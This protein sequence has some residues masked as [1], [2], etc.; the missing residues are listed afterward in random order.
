MKT[1]A[2]K[3]LLPNTATPVLPWLMKR[4]MRGTRTFSMTSRCLMLLQPL[5]L[6]LFSSLHPDAHPAVLVPDAP[7]RK[8]LHPSELPLLSC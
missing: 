2:I 1:A 7:T 5:H 8:D 3:V 6:P 4:G